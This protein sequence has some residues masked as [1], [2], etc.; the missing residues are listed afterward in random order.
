MPRMQAPPKGTGCR[1]R[2]RGGSEP[3]RRL[4][5][6]EIH[7]NRLARASAER[8]DRKLELPDERRMV[9]ETAENVALRE[10]RPRVLSGCAC[11]RDELVG[12]RVFDRDRVP[13]SVLPREV[14][15]VRRSGERQQTV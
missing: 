2:R 12:P 3:S 9:A 10:E 1:R 8:S 13:G 4:A 5:L 6:V 7:A 11:E 14:L 15:Q